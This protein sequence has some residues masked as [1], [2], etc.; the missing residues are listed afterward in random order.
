MSVNSTFQ[1]VRPALGVDVVRVTRL[2]R[3]F[4]WWET[5]AKHPGNTISVN[6]PSRLGTR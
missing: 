2:W 3:T 6:L 5:A 1:M 4:Y